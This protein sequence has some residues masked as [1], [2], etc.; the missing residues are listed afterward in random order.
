MRLLLLFGPQA[1]GKMTV[2]QA[3]TRITPLRLFHNHM[4]IEPVLSIF[5]GYRST[6]VQRLREVIFEDFAV[7]DEYGLIFTFQ[8]A[9]NYQ[10]DWDYTAHI[11]SIFEAHGAQVD[12]CELVAPLDVRLIRN[13]TENRLCEK[14]SKRNLEQSRQFVM[15]AVGKYRDT[16][17]PGE[18]QFPRYLRLDNS[19]LPPEEA[20]QKIAAYFGY[21]RTDSSCNTTK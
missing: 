12:Y 6:T 9:F 11:A 19:Q 4:T 2:G 17:E 13:E 8:W 10:E 3:L 21:Q 16:S 14:P 20:A 7:S 15:N 1:V 18:L 5:G